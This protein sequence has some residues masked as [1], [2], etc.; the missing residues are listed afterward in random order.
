MILKPI[1]ELKDYHV[2]RIT[3]KRVLVAI[4]VND[5]TSSDRAFDLACT[6]SFPADRKSVV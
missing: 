6:I 4:D 3:P 2:K 1:E 5:F